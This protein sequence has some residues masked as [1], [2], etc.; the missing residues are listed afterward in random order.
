L[1][2]NARIIQRINNPKG[3]IGNSGNRE[4]KHSNID[5]QGENLINDHLCAKTT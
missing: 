4:Q 5:V 1:F 3:A 2:R